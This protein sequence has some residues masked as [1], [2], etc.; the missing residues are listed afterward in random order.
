M[1]GRKRRAVGKFAEC[2][3][4]QYRSVGQAC[5]NF[6]QQFSGGRVQPVRIFDPDQCRPCAGD[7]LDKEDE[8]SEPLTL[9]ERGGWCRFF[10]STRRR[11]A[12]KTCNDFL[13]LGAV[14]PEFL[15]KRRYSCTSYGF[16]FLDAKR[17]PSP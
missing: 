15:Q 16:A 10:A 2:E 6:P 12:E 9:D 5:C 13:V 1:G 8:K 11:E 14:Y 3:K 4:E 7:L 17:K